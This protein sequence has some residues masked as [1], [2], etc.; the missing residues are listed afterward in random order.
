MKIR[1]LLTLSVAILAI[2]VVAKA[3]FISYTFDTAGRL[4][5]ANY[6]AGRTTS[7]QYDVTGNLVRSQNAVITDS[8]NDGM[9]DSWETTYFSTL[10][11]DGTGD[12]D[13]DG[14]SDVAEFLAGTLPDNPGS[15]LRMDRVTN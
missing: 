10:A 15:L 14:M 1:N 3:E 11:R 12:Y 4:T 7:Y 8:D 9:A 2:L 6:G 5:G 13:N